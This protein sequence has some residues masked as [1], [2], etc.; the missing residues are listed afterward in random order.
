MN[1]SN[2]L[3]PEMSL[4]FRESQAGTLVADDDEDLPLRAELFSAAQMAAH[5]KTLAQHHELSKRGGRDRLLSRLAENAAV[6][7]ST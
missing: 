1:K 3:L 6:I 7:D 5:G 4:G 2:P